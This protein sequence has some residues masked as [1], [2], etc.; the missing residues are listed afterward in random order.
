MSSVVQA[1][2]AAIV[3]VDRA[4][5]VALFVIVNGD[6]SLSADSY[7][8]AVDGFV[9]H[10]LAGD[11]LEACRHREGRTAPGAA[12]STSDINEPDDDLPDNYAVILQQLAALPLTEFDPRRKDVARDLRM[13]ASTLDAEVQ[14]CRGD[15]ETD[16]A[17][18]GFALDS[19]EP[20]PEP[21]G[22]A[23]LVDDV[24]GAIQRHL[25]HPAATSN[26]FWQE[27]RVEGV[28]GMRL[29]ATIHERPQPA[30]RCSFER[31]RDATHPTNE[32]PK[33][34]SSTREPVP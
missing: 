21:V 32:I 15:V 4:D 31:R 11:P 3:L 14:K 29:S 9:V 1:A 8:A 5:T 30:A 26:L 19:P 6:R 20:W 10:F 16:V 17:S 22:E 25:M 12:V 23:N 33:D 24:R 13:R 7:P 27:M 28:S 18:D 2:T 34:S